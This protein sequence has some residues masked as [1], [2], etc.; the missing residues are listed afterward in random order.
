MRLTVHKPK[1]IIIGETL[2]QAMCYAEE[3]IM[4]KEETIRFTRTE[5][6]TEDTLYMLKGINNAYMLRGYRIKEVLLVGT[7]SISKIIYKYGSEV[8][9]T[10]RHITLWRDGAIKEV[11]E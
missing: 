5:L 2:E 6:E 4:K 9:N 7:I 1:V 3:I 11:R 8:M 10:L